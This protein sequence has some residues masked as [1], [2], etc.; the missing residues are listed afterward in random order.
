VSNDGV[1]IRNKS[2][3]DGAVNSNIFVLKRYKIKL[4][5]SVIMFLNKINAA[6]IYFYM[7]MSSNKRTI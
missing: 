5:N 3:T 1:I 6:K 4:K 2:F 7:F